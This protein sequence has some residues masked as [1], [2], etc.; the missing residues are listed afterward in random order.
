MNSFANQVYETCENCL[1]GIV[2]REF[3]LD[4]P[5][6]IADEISL[7]DHSTTARHVLGVVCGFD[8]CQYGDASYC[9]AKQISGMPASFLITFLR[10]VDAA[11]SRSRRR[12]RSG[13]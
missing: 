5:S 4:L 6:C 7:C 10:T 2:S 3:R 1:D 13:F 11:I 9:E 12:Q 8:H